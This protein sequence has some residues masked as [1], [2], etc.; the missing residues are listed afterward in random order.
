MN[1]QTEEGIKEAQTS[2]SRGLLTFS[3]PMYSKGQ[4]AACIIFHSDINQ[5]INDSVKTLCHFIG[6]GRTTTG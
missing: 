3:K 2:K 4:T 1:E 5:I 6:G